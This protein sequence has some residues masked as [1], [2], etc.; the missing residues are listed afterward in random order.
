MLPPVEADLQFIDAVPMTMLQNLGDSFHPESLPVHIDAPG[1]LRG[2]CLLCGWM[3]DL[4]RQLHTVSLSCEG[5]AAGGRSNTTLDSAAHNL[6]AHWSP[7]R[8]R[9]VS[10]LYAPVMGHTLILPF[11]LLR[12]SYKHCNDRI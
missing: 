6:D 3:F 4:R 5:R 12:Q 1:L 2:M 11:P 9:K 10:K 8:A 7:S